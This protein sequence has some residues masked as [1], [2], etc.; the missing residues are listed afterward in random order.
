MRVSDRVRISKKWDLDLHYLLLFAAI[1][2]MEPSSIQ[3]LVDND[4]KFEVVSEVYSK[5]VEKVT[6][7]M[8]AHLIFAPFVSLG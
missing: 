3:V 4:L 7:L 6:N 8:V 5:V 2:Y 1:Y